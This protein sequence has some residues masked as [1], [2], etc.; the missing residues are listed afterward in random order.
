MNKYIISHRRNNNLEE[1]VGNNL[2]TNNDIPKPK[3]IKK[4][5]EDISQED[6][7]NNVNKDNSENCNYENNGKNNNNTH[8]HNSCN[9]NN[10][11]SIFIEKGIF[12]FIDDINLE[13]KLFQYSKLLKKRFKI[14]LKDYIKKYSEQLYYENLK[15]EPIIGSSSSLFE[16]VLSNNIIYILQDNLEKDKF[17]DK[18]CKILN[19]PNLDYSTIYYMFNNNNFNDNFLDNLKKFIYRF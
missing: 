11:K 1:K 19:K 17:K 5:D 9:I 3:E 14:D 12:S 15:D 8:N 2:I 7:N 18:Y 10:I 6:I 16:K 4:A 13:Y